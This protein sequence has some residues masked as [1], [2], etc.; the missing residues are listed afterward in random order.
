MNNVKIGDQVKDEISGVKGIIVAQHDYL[1]GCH[2]SRVQ[3]AG[4]KDGKPIEQSTFDTAQLKLITA[5]VVAYTAPVPVAKLGDKVRDRLTGY[6]GVATARFEYLFGPPAI[7]VQP[8]SLKD[9][10]P[11]ES[12]TFDEMQLEVVGRKP[13]VQPAERKT[14]GPRDEPRV[15]RTAPVR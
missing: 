10:K 4:M 13:V 5:G 9:G 15:S 6:E 11:A 8:Q 3:P 2:R 1:Y 14:G 7:G 12:F